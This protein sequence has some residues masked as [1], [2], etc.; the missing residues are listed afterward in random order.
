[1]LVA[2]K[3]AYR[4]PST[5]EFAVHATDLSFEPGTFTVITGPTGCGKS[6][7]LRLLSGLLQRHGGGTVTGGVSWQGAPLDKMLPS[8]R[9]R[10]L[11]FVAQNPDDQLIAGT[12]GDEIAFAAE[13]AGESAAAIEERIVDLL[14]RMGLPAEPDRDV[15][16]LSGGQRQ[17]LVVAAALSGGGHVLLLDEPLAHLDPTGAGELVRLLRAVA[18]GG[19]LV[20]AVEHRLEAIYDACDRVIVME[21][22]RVVQNAPRAELRGDTLRKLGLVVPVDVALRES[23]E[24][25]VATEA[26]ESATGAG[27][28]EPPPLI[29]ETTGIRFG[30]ARG[31]PVLNVDA[32]R[33]FAGERIAIVGPNGAGKSTLLGVMTGE[34][35]PSVTTCAGRIVAVPQ[36]PDLSLFCA[37][38]REELAY[39]PRDLGIAGEMSTL[40]EAFSLGELLDRAPQALSRGQRL[41]TAVAAALAAKPAVLALDEPTAGQDFEQVE[42]LM[43]AIERTMTGGVLLFATH[44]LSLALR[45]A[46]RVIV[47]AEGRLIAEGDPAEILDRADIAALLP[48]NGALGRCRDLGISMREVITFGSHRS[49]IDLLRARGQ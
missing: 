6:T 7:L 33:F 34:F 49:P 10:H 30:Y 5:G 44:D 35:G 27:Q 39:A 20:I 47:L 8:Q 23:R 13:S 11:G 40:V 43:F 42:R 9:V 22:G 46:T 14:A 17:R 37:S 19:K 18:D 25:R 32:L 29:L 48:L 24:E 3:L 1:M 45:H 21:A 12:L 36:D 41:R 26:V 4:Y 31:E 15:R 16:A 2:T 38:V 28:A